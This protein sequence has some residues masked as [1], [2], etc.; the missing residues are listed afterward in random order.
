MVPERVPVACPFPTVA[1]DEEGAAKA[2]RCENDGL[3]L[4][5]AETALL[6][7]VAERAHTPLTILQQAGDRHLHMDIDALMDAVVLK[8]PDHFESG[9]IS[10]VRETRIGM[11]TEIALQNLA[12]RRSVEERA[13][14]LELARTLRRLFRVVLRH[15]PTVQVLTATHRVG[16]VNIPAVTLVDIR[17][18]RR[19][20]TLGHDGV[21]LTEKRLT[22]QTDGYA[23]SRSFDGG[24]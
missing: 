2:T 10:H 15:T 20:A 16:E 11:S 21:C 8:R 5:Y 3:R 6:A 14:R 17:H 4:V 12:V 24:P 7:I 23:F 9:P 19:H 22:D 18:R 13:P 1:C